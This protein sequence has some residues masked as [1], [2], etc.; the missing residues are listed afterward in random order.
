[1]KLSGNTSGIHAI[2]KGALTALR[3]MLEITA[4]TNSSF[5]DNAFDVERIRSLRVKLAQFFERGEAGSNVDVESIKLLQESVEL[6]A[7]LQNWRKELRV[8]SA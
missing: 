6:A 7:D 1:M 4:Q 8:N 3:E 5:P 2:A